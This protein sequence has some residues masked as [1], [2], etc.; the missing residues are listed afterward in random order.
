MCGI[1][2]FFDKQNLNYQNINYIIDKMNT[3][4]SHRG[5]D[6]S[7][8]FINVEKNFGFKMCR[9]SILDLEL[10]VQPMHSIDGRYV[11]IFNG[12]ILNSPDLRKKLEEQNIKFKSK[13]SD[14][15]V[16]LNM[17]IKYGT[18]GLMELNG[19]FA[20]A[21]YDKKD[22]KLL[23]ARD[24]FGLA[25]FYYY[26]KNDKFL[27][28]SELKSLFFSGLISKEINRENLNHYLSLLWSPG[29][30]TII[31][32]I[33]KL[34]P[35][36]LLEVDL[37]NNSLNLSRWFNF[38][39][40]PN[41]SKNIDEWCEAIIENLEKSVINSTLSDV[42]LSC[43]L[44]GGLDS[45]SIVAILSKHNKNLKS[46]SLGFKGYNKGPLNELEESRIASKYFNIDHQEIIIDKKNYFSELDKMIYHLDE[47]YG[48]GLPLWHVFKEAGKK[49]GVIVTGLGGDELFGTFG[50]WSLLERTFFNI[51][52]S[53]LQFKLLYFDRKY[54]FTDEMKNKL[55]LGG[56]T[57]YERTTD[58][59]F[60][61]IS[62]KNFQN[63]RDKVTNMILETQ[64]PDEYNNMVNKFS[65]ANN[66]E[67]R[68]PFLDNNLTN[69]IQEIPADKRTKREDF[70][71]LLRNSVKNILPKENLFNRKRGFVGLE[72]Q[73]I[74]HNFEYIFHDLFNKK[75]IEAQEIFNYK[76]LHNFL[77][78]FKNNGNFKEITNLG[79]LKN[80]NYKS[81]WGLIM[82]Q[83][84][85]DIFMK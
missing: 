55:L 67:A 84:W 78:S 34:Q 13:N 30:D 63:V 59:L 51:T 42:P 21:L 11:I 8:Q 19:S 62:N 23:C 41:H 83:K 33:K 72:S 70:K 12:T 35:G 22:K 43:G 64:L 36:H 56:N 20:F 77:N 29:P 31:K 47:P 17:I 6:S 28:A 40:N 50:Q 18:E 75:K 37:N 32:N 54:F 52:N 44:S 80:Y 26:Q 5:P 66:I 9:L 82:F 71:Y 15:E 14:T 10:G 25:P 1:V 58:F 53:S 49:Y 16:L 45:Q 61:K 60:R 46:F 74:Q 73:N 85:H 79:Y 2:G 39:F 48:G 4:Q 24:R 76:I 7:G 65:M 57:N 69:L 68:A 3:L 27:F 81:L 38:N